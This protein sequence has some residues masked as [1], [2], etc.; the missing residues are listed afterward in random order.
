MAEFEHG[1]WTVERLEDGWGF[2]ARKDVRSKLSPSLVAWDNLP[3]AMREYDRK[4]V[5]EWLDIFGKAG[6]KIVRLSDDHA[7]FSRSRELLEKAK[8]SL[9]PEKPR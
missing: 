2:S 3:E 5:R 1:R 8:R 6:S 7:I 9:L 4:A